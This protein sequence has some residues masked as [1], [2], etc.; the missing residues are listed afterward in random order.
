M[1]LNK[2]DFAALQGNVRQIENYLRSLMPEVQDTIVVKFGNMVRRNAGYGCMVSESKYELFLEKDT[3]IG[4]SGCL[5]Y[6]FN[7]DE[8]DVS[9]CVCVYSRGFGEEFMQNLIRHWPK[10]KHDINLALDCQQR[11]L[12]GI[13]NFKL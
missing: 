7:P 2:E 4:G 12:D 5:R 8:A 6:V 13:R 9:G 10:I 11:K 1:V 3:L